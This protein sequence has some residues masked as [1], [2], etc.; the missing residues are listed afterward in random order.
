M[1]NDA[2]IWFYFDCKKKKDFTLKSL[3]VLT[4]RRLNC[5]N[6]TNYILWKQQTNDASVNWKEMLDDA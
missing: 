4:S 1:I 3:L 5:K 2:K 6:K